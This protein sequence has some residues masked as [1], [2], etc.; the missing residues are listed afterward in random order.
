MDLGADGTRWI[1]SGA[2]ECGWQF[3]VP[4]KLSLFRGGFE[5]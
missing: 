2:D 1:F 4:W 5:L 3:R